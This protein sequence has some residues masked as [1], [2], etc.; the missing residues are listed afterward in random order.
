MDELTRRAILRAVASFSAV[1]LLG[2]GIVFGMQRVGDGG[3]SATGSPAAPTTGPTTSP[4]A[5]PEA[6]ATWLAW[7][8]GGLPEGFG[9][10]VNAVTKVTSATT[11]TAGVAWLSQVLD[12]DGTVL[13]GPPAPYLFPLDVTGVE[14]DFAQFVP[15]SGRRVVASL[16]P[17]E[18]ILSESAAARREVGAG[19][20]LQFDPG[21]AVTIVTTLPDEQMGG[22]ELLVLRS[23]GEELG[24]TAERYVLFRTRAS[25]ET[26]AAELAS[27]FLQLIPL[28]AP[29][30]EVEVR[31]PGATRWLRANDREL[32]VSVLKGKFG[33]FAALPDPVGGSFELDPAWVQEN[34]VSADIAVFGE[35][36]CHRKALFL[37]KRAAQELESAAQGF[38]VADAGP[39]FDPDASATDPTGYLTAGVFGAAIQLNVGDNEPGVE[40]VQPPNLISTMTAWGFS[41]AGR[42]AY[43]QGALFSYRRPPKPGA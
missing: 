42:D 38:L 13:G 7:V 40:P 17:G 29:Y 39:C 34:L 9:A 12:A 30:P 35:V 25:V 18:G 16:D 2:S 3:P 33:E 37:L 27:R 5:D 24:V 11:A 32:P 28:D 4:T 10:G 36:T 26:G 20:T 43:P 6:P 41:W 1:L 14:S 15:T 19:A 23:T 21:G 31:P 22:Y 8:P